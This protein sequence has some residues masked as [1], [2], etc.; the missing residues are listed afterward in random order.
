[1][2]ADR[3]PV[4][5]LLGGGQLG[6]MLCE[7]ANP[8]GI[9]IAILDEEN[10][11]AKQ[12]HNTNRHV[13]GSFK[14]PAR[15]RELAA[16]SDFLSVE[17]E[18][19]ET[20]VLEDI[21]KNGVEVKQAD[22]TTKTHKPPVHPSWKTIRL[23]QDKYLQKEHFRTSDK[24]IPIAE[25]VAIE[26]GPAAL[27]S[28]KNAAAKFGLPF[29]LKARKGSYDGRGNFKV[30]SEKDFEAAVTALGGLSLYAEKW[31][32][33]VKELAVMVIRTEDDNGTL[34]NCVAYPAVETIHE[35]SIC[36]KVFMPPRDVSETVCAAARKLATE[37]ISTL[38]GRGVFAVEMFVL[39][40]GSLMVN[41]VAPRPHN[42]GHYTI[43]AVPQMSQYKAQIHAV[44][45]L[46]V[47]QKLTPRVTSSI[48]LNILGGATPSA[49]LP[50]AEL[51]R[52]T[53][54]DDM[55]IHLHLYN[56]ASKPGRK[57]GHITLTSTTLPIH[58]LETKAQPLTDL[59]NQ[60]RHDRITASAETLRPTTTTT[61]PT[62]STALTPAPPSQTT[63]PAPLVLITMGSDS[64]LPVLS[65]GLA[66][67]REFGVPYAVD[68][69]SAHR[70]ARYMMEV[71]S[72]AAERGVRVV[73][74]AAGGAAHLPG[75]F[76]SETPLP[77]IGV[78]VKATHL[79]GVDSLLS[80]VQM[81][82]GVPTATVGINNSTNAALLAIRILG[83]SMPEYQ[84]K[85]KRYQ[86]NMEEQV[87]EKGNKLR[88][89]GD[90]E[91]L[92]AKGK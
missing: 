77:V 89:I 70:T 49:H 73:V 16:Q 22:G 63:S 26:S 20:E 8:L 42:S 28:L 55:D 51:A 15:I 11:P 65:A 32:P 30:D 23:I 48:M 7:A 87:I 90:V 13:V 91:Y 37:V 45:D 72:G 24:N 47:P 86:A 40:D 17:I 53:F 69:T 61:Q 25:Q 19:V 74:A 58:D 29:M 5:G 82:R 27:D 60:I 92:A 39:E 12:A 35:D 64:D 34:K 85:M 10:S 46:P 43:E 18:H 75:M 4:I 41:E 68:I 33:F 88:E 67:L 56:K 54:D 14:D 2:T 36:T 66:I 52:K 79:D 62:P 80:I 9:D 50:L 84:E 1:M 38:W 57:I 76:A 44:L 31:A 3:N 78:P 21:E 83:S 81:P 71:A 59:V 6:R